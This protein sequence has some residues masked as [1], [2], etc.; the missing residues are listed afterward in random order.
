MFIGI[1]ANNKHFVINTDMT[2][3]TNLNAI[4]TEGCCIEIEFGAIG[5][6]YYMIT[7]NLCARTMPAQT[8]HG[9]F[10]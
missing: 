7:T 8:G 4:A 5:F 9:N 3:A 6:E 10:F 2:R 1:I